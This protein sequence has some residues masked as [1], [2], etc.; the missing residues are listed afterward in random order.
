MS[1]TPRPEPAAGRAVFYAPEV[2]FDRPIPKVPAAVFFAEREAAFAVDAP[3]GMIACDVAKQLKSPWPA[4]TPTMLARYVVVRSGD[5]LDHQLNSSGEV[6]YVIRGAGETDCVGERFAWT[7]GDAFC[8]PGG[9]AVR[10][11]ASSDAILMLVTNEPELDY[12]RAGPDETA[13]EPT[14]FPG[15]IIEQHLRNVHGRNGEQ[16][17]AGKSVVFLTAMMAE[18]RVTTP[19]LLSAINTLEPGADQRPHRHSSAALTLSIQGEGVYSTLD[20]ERIDWLP[21]TLFVTPP[22]AEH[23]HH[24]RG[25]E[26]MRSFVVQ[27]TGLHSQLRTTNFGWTD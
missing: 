26:M 5:M 7:C 3:T 4:T 11:R 19:T 14:L 20:G 18:R 25:R 27:D 10:H 23:S 22:M 21:D 2:A 17:A 24:N 13:I 9:E 1:F 6:Y 16:Q 8:L 15:E 12:L